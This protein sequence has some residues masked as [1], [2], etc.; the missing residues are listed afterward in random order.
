MIFFVKLLY[1]INRTFY[2][3]FSASHVFGNEIKLNVIESSSTAASEYKHPPTLQFVTS[4]NETVVL[5]KT[6]E[7]FCIYGGL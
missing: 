2:I 6:A 1:K 3:I 5:G 4:K 7:L